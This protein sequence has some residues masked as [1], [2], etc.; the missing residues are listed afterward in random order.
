MTGTGLTWQIFKNHPSEFSDPGGQVIE[1][2]EMMFDI[3]RL[4]CESIA[5]NKP[6]GSTAI[7]KCRSN[8]SKRSS[9]HWRELRIKPELKVQS[10]TT[11][12][13]KRRAKNHALKLS[14]TNSSLHG[15]PSANEYPESRN[16]SKRRVRNVVP[17][18]WRLKRSWWTTSQRH[19]G[20]GFRVQSPASIGLWTL[21]TPLTS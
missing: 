1:A 5:S 2:L 18:L 17:Y 11:V 8:Q 12:K 9:A 15:Q 10:I 14:P 7:V 21:K 16:R 20:A 19:R 3:G 4:V 13:L 6:L